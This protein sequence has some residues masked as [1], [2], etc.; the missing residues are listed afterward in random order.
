MKRTKKKKEKKS[1]SSVLGRLGEP[2]KRRVNIDRGSPDLTVTRKVVANAESEDEDLNG[3]P[4]IRDRLQIKT[5]VKDR[6]DVKPS[7]TDRLGKRHRDKSRKHQEDSIRIVRATSQQSD[8]H[9]KAD[10]DSDS[11]DSHSRH[12]NG[13]K[14]ARLNSIWSRRNQSSG[15][16]RSH[17][18][19][20]HRDGDRRSKP[21]PEPISIWTSKR[22]IDSRDRENETDVKAAKVA[23]HESLVEEK[24]KPKVQ[25]K[26]QGKYMSTTLLKKAVTPP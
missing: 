20:R 2:I 6:L 22:V 17:S 8:T 25:E 13:A 23:R 14:S 18:R 5:S 9:A 4:S 15:N 24:P 19:E 10:R 26:P 11:D 16:H 3:K 7:I 12:G 21:K 1:K